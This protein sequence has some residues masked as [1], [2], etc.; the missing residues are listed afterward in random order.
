MSGAQIELTL[1]GIAAVE[2]RLG[3]LASAD[4]DDLAFDA[5][6]LIEASTRERIATEKTSPEGAAWPAWSTRHA[7]SRK[8]SHSLLVEGNSLL[9]SI[10][11]YTQGDTVKVGSNLVYAAI[12]QFGGKAGRGRKVTIPARPYL[13]LSD[14]DREAVEALVIDRV[15]ELVL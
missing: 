2:A 15:E 6:A 8:A 7:A 3:R 12:H 10:Q 9:T 11:N 5:G 1:Q 14:A 13:G 4:L